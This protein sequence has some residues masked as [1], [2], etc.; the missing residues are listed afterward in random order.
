MR[1]RLAVLAVLAAGVLSACGGGNPTAPSAN[2]GVT[3]EGTMLGGT[4]ALPFHASAGSAAAAAEITV[5]C[6]ENQAITAIVGPDG[7]FTLRGLPSGTFT[8]DFTRGGVVIAFLTFREVQPNQQITITVAPSGSTLTVVEEKRN[9][10]GHGDLEIEGLVQSVVILN[11][12]GDSRFVI[13][14]YTVVARPGQT[15]IREGNTARTVG[16]VTVGRQ[17]HVKGTWLPLEG[18]VQPVLAAEIMLQDTDETQAPTLA[19]V[20]GSKAEVEGKIT[21]I[22]A[23]TSTITV[24]Q[25]GH[26]LYECTVPAGTPIRKG[27]QTYRFPELS[28]GWRVHVKGTAQGL[29]AGA[30][31]VT[32][33]EVIVQQN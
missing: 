11:P 27:N 10:I 18:A 16:D 13:A 31:R 24:D 15:A 2:G 29:A 7:S 14:G 20:V 8:L 12:A 19:C 17:V 32:A 4:A 9:G 26:G 25:Q 22:V 33:S 30:C 28:T 1:S 23:A 21:G 6:R 5:K 3:L